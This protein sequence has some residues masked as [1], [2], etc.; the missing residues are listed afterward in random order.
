MKRR[1]AREGYCCEGATVYNRSADLFAAGCSITVS[2]PSADFSRLAHS[3]RLANADSL[4]SPERSRSCCPYAHAHAHVQS[5][6]NTTNTTHL[7]S[8]SLHSD[9]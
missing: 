9:R 5:I 4:L 2:L 1:S 7:T 6:L 3:M 8:Q